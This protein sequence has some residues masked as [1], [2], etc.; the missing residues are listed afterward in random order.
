MQKKKKKNFT[1][2]VGQM[3]TSYNFDKML[4]VGQ[5]QAVLKT[6]NPA[7]TGPDIKTSL[8]STS[9]WTSWVKCLL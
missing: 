5:V 8:R 6:H 1:P 4:R 2:W 3:G 9:Q 7:F